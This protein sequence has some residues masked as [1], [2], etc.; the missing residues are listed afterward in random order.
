MLR[1]TSDDADLTDF[2]INYMRIVVDKMAGRLRVS[3][4]T[5]KDEVQN[6]WIS[7]IL[8][9]NDWE[10]FQ[11]I[12]YRAAIRD[13]DSYVMVDPQTLK[14]M[15]EPA[16]DGFS[17]IVAIFASA[18]DY[19]LW[20]CKLWSEVD[21]AVDQVGEES[22]TTVAMKL[23]V[24]QPNSI[25]YWKGG[26]GTQ[27]VEED[28]RVIVATG[29]VDFMGHDQEWLLSF[30]P[31]I[32]LANLIDNYTRYGESELRVAIPP[33]NVLNRTLHS[34]VMASEFA[35][36]KIAWSIGLELDKSGI[37]PGAVLNLV[38]TDSSGKVITELT[39]D[40]IAF[41]QACRVGEFAE[42]DI[43]QYT[44]QLAEIVKHISQETQTPIYG[45]TAEGNLSGEALKQLEIGLIGKVK[46]FQRE[47]TGAIRLL[48]ELTAAIQSKFE[49]EIEGEA[50]KLE[51]ISINWQSPEIL[52]QGQQITALVTMREKAPGLFDD[53]FYRQRIGGILDLSQTQIKEEGE[54]ATNSQS[55]LFETMSGGGGSVPIV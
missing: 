35:A 33:Q 12:L 55:M 53:D 28:Q 11:G 42:T 49:T 30:V 46:R 26:V 5:T 38:L 54:K 9:Y 6:K 16:Y 41:L 37:T 23:T 14:W 48:I 2:S 31:I 27:E 51:G 21:T 1:L 43:S 4:I 40:Q 25:T 34:M 39:A 36:F 10:S 20:A 18:Q 7:N 45:V 13:G 24:Y 19:P 29:Q 15:A 3:E 44:N 8:T 22:S 32:H 52:D 17:G 50:P 47:N